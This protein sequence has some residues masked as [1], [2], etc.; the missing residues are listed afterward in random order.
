MDLVGVRGPKPAVRRGSA[1]TPVF[2]R[3]SGSVARAVACPGAF[4]PVENEPPHHRRRWAASARAGRRSSLHTEHPAHK[5]DDA[6]LVLES[7]LLTDAARANATGY[8][9]EPGLIQRRAHVSQVLVAKRQALRLAI[10]LSGR[11]A[12]GRHYPTRSWKATGAACPRRSRSR[13]SASG[14]CIQPSIGARS[15]SSCSCGRRV[16]LVAAA[17]ATRAL[18][19][20]S[21][22]SSSATEASRAP[23]AHSSQLSDPPARSSS[24]PIRRSRCGWRSAFSFLLRPPL[25]FDA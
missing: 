21:K 22:A 1:G 10:A 16:R 6:A 24:S 2:R 13:H 3:C 9:I 19:T 17:R 18:S 8:R 7:H 5:L 23:S 14:R 25:Y 15:T 20:A 4:R 12:V 11:G